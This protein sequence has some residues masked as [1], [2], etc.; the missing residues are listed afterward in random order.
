MNDDL[1]NS[2]LKSLET[3]IDILPYLPGL[4]IDL[5]T[6][7]CS[8][9]SV[10]EILKP[11]KLPPLKTKVLDLGC[12]KGAVSIT[13]ASKLG[14]HATGIDAN[15]YFLSE[16]EKKAKEFNVSNLC[17]FQYGDIREYVTTAEN[18][19]IVVYASLGNILGN[20]NKIIKRLRKT[21]RKGGYII[22]DDGYLTEITKLKRKGYRHYLSRDE[23]VKQLTSH[24]DILKEEII[25]PR[26]ENKAI[27]DEYLDAIR[28]RGDELIEQ[29][30]KLRRVVTQ[31]I[32]SQEIEC[33][34]LDKYFI[35]AIW[36]IERSK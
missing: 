14:F 13:L 27:N 12:G 34:I 32:K 5:W 26:E 22:I 6:L 33:E 36:L 15:K 4:L 1:N 9:Q 10:V 30:P 3:E 31:Y 24:G 17:E 28:I 29:N 11:L 20:F 21:V 2:V 16:A 25:I 19:D 23:T 35:G 7:G 18:F 8:P